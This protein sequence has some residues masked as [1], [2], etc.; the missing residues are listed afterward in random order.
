MS[1]AYHTFM[2]ML[3]E[4]AILMLMHALF[5]GHHNSVYAL[6]SMSVFLLSWVGLLGKSCIMT[7]FLDLNAL[8]QKHTYMVLSRAYYQFIELDYVYIH[9]WICQ[10]S[11]LRLFTSSSYVG[12]QTVHDF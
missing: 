8:F 12:I 4:T 9:S 1:N 10:E 3:N 7:G 6:F 2:Y 5:P 11:M